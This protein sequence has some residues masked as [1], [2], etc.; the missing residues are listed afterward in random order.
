MI[1][2]DRLAGAAVDRWRDFVDDEVLQRYTGETSKLI[3]HSALWKHAVFMLP[4]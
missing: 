3:K 4:V 2:S 1:K